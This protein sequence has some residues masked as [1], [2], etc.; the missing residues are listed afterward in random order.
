MFRR[1]LLTLSQW[2]IALTFFKVCACSKSTE[3]LTFVV[4][5]SQT[6][7]QKFCI[8]LQIFSKGQRHRL[9]RCFKLEELGTQTTVLA[10]QDVILRTSSFVY[11]HPVNDAVRHIS[12]SL[13]WVIQSQFMFVVVCFGAEKCA[14][15][16]NYAFLC[17]YKISCLSVNGEH[18]LGIF[19]NKATR[20]LFRRRKNEETVIWR[21]STI[22]SF[23]VCV[24]HRM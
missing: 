7:V 2:I 17:G 21:N 11:F 6:H 4:F 15:L 22:R 19:K 24:L 3:E 18:C 8:P 14:Q 10:V 12:N 16:L 20:R 5:E 23:I 13:Q 9:S 1:S